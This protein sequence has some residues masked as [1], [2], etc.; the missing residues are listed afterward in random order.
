MDRELPKDLREFL[1]LLRAHSV[2]YLL[3]G[4]WAVSQETHNL[5]G[6]IIC[7]LVEANVFPE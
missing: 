6:H 3:V 2:E 5:I 1:R 7:E 4:G